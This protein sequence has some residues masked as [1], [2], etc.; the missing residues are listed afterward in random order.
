MAY[1][2]GDPIINESI[3]FRF[4]AFVVFY[5]VYFIAINFLRVKNLTRH[6]GMKKLTQLK[7]AVV[8][9]NH[10]S[11]LDPVKMAG[12]S[13]PWR[14]WHTMLE[15]TVESPFLGTFVRLLGGVPIPAEH[16]MRTIL[17]DMR[18]LLRYRR[19]L[20]FYPEGECFVYNQDLQ[21]FQAG[22]FFIAAELDIPIEPLVMVFRPMPFPWSLIAKHP[23]ET[24]YALDPLYPS[25]YIR[26]D[27]KGR[28]L[29]RSIREFSQAARSAMQAE[30]DRR[31]GDRRWS[32]GR[33]ERIK[34]INK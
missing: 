15:E 31:G 21:P 13:M 25:Q 19:Y 34:G 7:Q 23:Q 8:I 20:M 24:V 9:S 32:R 18:L 10:T 28:I 27:A 1:K 17:D 5:I 16:N 22:A 33:M 3:P 26:R 6:I 29:P 12:A 11:F 2:H 4:A 14:M 30:I